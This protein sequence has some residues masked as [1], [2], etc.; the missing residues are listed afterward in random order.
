MRGTVL[1]PTYSALFGVAS[2][3]LSTQ[4]KTGSCQA[5]VSLT[6]ARREVPILVGLRL[7]L[8][9]VWTDDAARMERAGVPE[10]AQAPRTK[11]EIALDEVDRVRAAGTR[12]GL[13]LADTGYGCSAT[14]RAGL[15]ARGLAWAVGV[16]SNL[17]VYPADVKLLPAEPKAGRPSDFLLPVK[18][19]EPAEI[20]L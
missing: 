16:P 17:K 15:S 4:G 5:L 19:S 10:M 18:A 6:L 3:Y 9:A 8:P 2:Q 7:F 1:S 20:V 13:V 12:F 11:P 14:F